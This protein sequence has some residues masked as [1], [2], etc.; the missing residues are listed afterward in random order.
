MEFISL[1]SDEGQVFGLLQYS[2]FGH[3]CNPTRDSLQLSMLK[4]G[5]VFLKAAVVYTFRQ[6]SN[7][8]PKFNELNVI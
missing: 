3:H 2:A 6:N 1:P 7:T 5:E 8:H 4:E